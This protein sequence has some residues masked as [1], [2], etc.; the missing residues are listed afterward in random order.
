MPRPR[1]QEERYT[2]IPA[3]A[4]LLYFYFTF[5][6]T[7]IYFQVFQKCIKTHNVLVHTEKR[8]TFTCDI[9]HKVGLIYLIEIFFLNRIVIAR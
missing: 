1:Q 9:C 3:L 8:N 6:F 5:Y 7:N 2:I 4:Q